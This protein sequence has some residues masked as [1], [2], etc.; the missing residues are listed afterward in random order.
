MTYRELL[1]L[2]KEGKLNGQQE[3][4]VEADIEK[5]EAI[6]EFL[7]AEE[8]VPGLDE[9]LGQSD[10]HSSE[11][12]IPS[13][14]SEADF[15][16]LVNRSIRRAFLKLGAAVLALALA[17]TLFVQFALPRIV[18]AFYYNPGKEI[19]EHTNQISLDL[20]VYTE[21]AVPGY[22]GDSVT[23]DQNGYGDYDIF[24]HQTTSLNGNFTNVSGKIRKN[25]LL[26]Y[27]M[28]LL[29]RPT[30]NCFAW[31]QS[32]SNS[33]KSLTE[34]SQE[35]DG[36]LHCAAGD[37]VQAAETLENL[38]PNAKYICYVSLDSLMTYKEFMEF[39][40]GKEGFASIWCAVRTSAYPE[41]LFLTDNL[42]FQ[43]DLLTSTSLNWDNETY[44]NLLLWQSED[45][46]DVLEESM[47]D[48]A[49]MKTHFTSMLRY[50]AKQTA[51]LE[52]MGQNPEEFR[53]AAE[54]VEEHGLIV[55][56]FAAHMSRETALAL[57]ELDEV[58][59]IY[60]EPAY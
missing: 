50:M 7:Y 30:G 44:P 26:L 4:Q 46:P 11:K 19:A 2:Y 52:M 31:F 6:S 32:S 57:N 36:L 28:N 33:T 59:E 17:F 60:A 45:D 51:F 55:Y 5:Q 49:F 56:G 41:S 22:F 35:N 43:C 34:Q 53:N 24:L 42:G 48:E 16:R 39:L 40:D 1:K 29:K 20:A 9:I 38:D 25:K 15:V 37:P 27:D 21:L 23:V 12:D 3:A 10:G 47:K 13:N 8:T 58:Y 18:S 14:R 54:Y